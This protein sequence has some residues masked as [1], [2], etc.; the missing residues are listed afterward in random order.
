MVSTIFRP[1]SATPGGGRNPQKRAGLR[2]AFTIAEVMVAACVMALVITTSI[3]TMQRAYLALDAARGTSYAA[4]MMQT[5]MEKIRLQNWS[6]VSAYSA[7]ST[8]VTIDSSFTN[9]SY[10]GNRYTM[11]RT[12]TAVHTGMMQI[13]LTI[14][15]ATYDGR[16]LSRS[17]TTYYGHNGLYDY[18]SS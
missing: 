17:Y 5:E 16:T 6:T 4:Q 10:I 3:T 7:T 8:P 12:A 11:T 2:R 1:E 15:W 9:N 13:T 18:V 14:S